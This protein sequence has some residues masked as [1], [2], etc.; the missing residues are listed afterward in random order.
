MYCFLYSFYLIFCQFQECKF[1][2]RYKSTT[3]EL[4]VE[5]LVVHVHPVMDWIGELVKDHNICQI[6]KWYPV[7]KYLVKNR[8]EIQ[9]WDDVDCGSDW[10]DIQ[11]CFPYIYNVS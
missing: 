1:N 9:I 8:E 11:V 5:E 3:G 2:C 4:V 10:W 7:H 6:M